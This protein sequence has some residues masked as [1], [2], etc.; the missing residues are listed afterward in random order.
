MGIA[1]ALFVTAFLAATL[2]P[3]SSEAAL[4]AALQSDV[5]PSL[6]IASATLGNTLGAALN[7]LL[8]LLV[9]Q[10]SQRVKLPVKQKT[11]D[12]YAHLFTRYGAWSLLFSWVPVV[13]DPLTVL[14]GLART[15]LIVFL[16]LVL[17]GKLFRYLAIAGWSRR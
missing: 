2:L 1:A 5:S 6:L 17:A 13:G 7:W 11:L 4:I 9:A 15:P 8:G 14:A 3:G 12:R 10:G 16:P